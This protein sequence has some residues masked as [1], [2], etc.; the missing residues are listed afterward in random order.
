MY[1]PTV[2]SWKA[3]AKLL[4][5]RGLHGTIPL[6]CAL[7][8]CRNNGLCQSRNVSTCA[9]PSPAVG[10]VVPVPHLKFVP[11]HFMFGPP[12]A[13]YIQYCVVKM[14]LLRLRNPGD[15]PT[16]VPR[17]LIFHYI[18]WF[19][20][21]YVFEED[22][23]SFF[24]VFSLLLRFSSF[25]NPQTIDYVNCCLKICTNRTKNCF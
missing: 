24:K 10:S 22:R 19:F 14:W 12:V 3:N 25:F 6:T 2:I 13:A 8:V 1:R 17:L 11:A 21:K 4:R 20:T 7:C 23:L 16:L 18:Y 9:G 5:G 15:G